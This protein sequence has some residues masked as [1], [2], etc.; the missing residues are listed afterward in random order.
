MTINNSNT[1]RFIE[2][3]AVSQAG[4]SSEQK[5]WDAVK[6]SKYKTPLF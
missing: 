3:E 2:T 5:V 1:S 6:G 4:A